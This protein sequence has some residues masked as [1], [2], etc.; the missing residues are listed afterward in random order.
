MEEMLELTKKPL[1]GGAVRHLANKLSKNYHSGQIITTE[2]AIRI[3]KLADN[4]VL[5]NCMCRK[6]VGAKEEMVCLNFGPMRDL[7][8]NANPKEKMEEIDTKEAIY[9]I[10][11][12]NREGLIPEVLYAATPF[13]IAVCNCDRKYCIPFKY[14]LTTN[15]YSS[16]MKGHDIAVVDPKK[17]KC[18]Q[19]HC[20]IRC[21]FGAIYKD[22]ENNKAIID[23]TKCF[24]CGLCRT[25]CPCDAITMKDREKTVEGRNIW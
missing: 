12:W 25:P 9:R 6:M 8:K 4:H 19:F 14:R 3:A 21:P 16:Y 17:C 10:K 22:I 20:I 1:I 24:G 5:F 15:T 11:E 18:E 2:D 23:V 7:C 13:P